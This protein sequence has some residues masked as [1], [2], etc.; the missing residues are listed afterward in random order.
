MAP[1]DAAMAPEGV[2]MT[3]RFLYSETLLVV[4]RRL[5]IQGME[6]LRSVMNS[7]DIPPFTVLIFRSAARETGKRVLGTFQT[8]PL[9]IAVHEALVHGD[10]EALLDEVL[11][12][13]LAHLAAW[14]VD[15]HMGHGPPFRR[16]CRLLGIPERAT[17][18][19]PDDDPVGAGEEDETRREQLGARVRK[20]LALGSSPHPEE[21][22]EAV[23]KAN[24][25]I[26]RHNLHILE[27]AADEDLQTPGGSVLEG[28]RVWTGRRTPVEVKLI[29]GL[30][31]EFFGVYPLFERG[32][33][34]GHLMLYGN[35][36]SLDVAEY[37]FTTLHRL[38]L[39]HW[40][41]HRSHHRKNGTLR[42]RTSF[43]VGYFEGYR[44]TLS[45]EHPGGAGHSGKG[46]S[47]RGHSDGGRSALVAL[48]GELEQ[49]V[50]RVVHTD[51]V[52]RRTMRGT[53]YQRT[54]S[55]EGGLAA[56]RR[57]SVSPG[58]K[59]FRGTPPPQLTEN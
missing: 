30:L 35:R 44:E 8:D 51:R 43:L 47:G 28:A 49:Q 33:R 7:G 9:R 59:D 13:E 14:T 15:G 4:R 10:R 53:R 25:L 39:N 58:V 52:H 42:D 48:R 22:R 46:H 55:W 6:T 36:E 16:W 5:Q 45:R 37:L 57:T 54:P 29:A 40:H 2:A 17:C 31:G 24:E 18:G 56:G 38:A 1:E 20:L 19:P 12:H 23:R 26:L 3:H 11:R 41:I 32:N 34:E 27:S 50:A 21:A